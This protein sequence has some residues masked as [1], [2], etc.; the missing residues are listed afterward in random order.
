LQHLDAV[1]L[2]H[3]NIEK[4]D[5][6]WHLGD[7]LEGIGA[8]DRGHHLIFRFKNHPEGLARPEFIIHD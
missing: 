2:A 1:H 6:G 4:N 7:E 8:V 3:P 5:I